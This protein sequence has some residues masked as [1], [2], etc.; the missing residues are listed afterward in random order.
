LNSPELHLVIGHSERRQHLFHCH[1]LA[2]C[3]A[4][5]LLAAQGYPL[6]ALLALPVVG[7]RLWRS[8]AQPM[9]GDALGWRA[10]Q[11]YVER[12]GDYQ[13]IE[14]SPRS[15]CLPWVVFLAWREQPGGRRGSLWLFA[16]SAEPP[17]LRRLRLRLGLQR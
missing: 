6:L 3:Y 7:L 8:R 5:Y 16:D 9:V 1:C 14:L 13:A 10:G 12:D 4:L 17:G 11:W 15:G 2:C